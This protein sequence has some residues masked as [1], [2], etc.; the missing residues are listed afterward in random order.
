M[1]YEEFLQTRVYKEWAKPQG[2]VDHLASTLDK[3]S[4]SFTL[5]GI[6]RESHGPFQGRIY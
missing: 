4:T 1:P 3:S 6:F 2:W 5:F